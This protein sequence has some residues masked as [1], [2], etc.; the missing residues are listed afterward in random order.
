MST[1][2]RV[3]QNSHGI[4]GEIQSTGLQTYSYVSI[5]LSPTDVG[6]GFEMAMSR[7]W[8]KGLDFFEL[9][10][11][12]AQKAEKMLGAKV[13]PSKKMPVILDER[14]TGQT[15]GSIVGFGVNG[16]TVMTGISY[17]ADKIG[18]E[19][20]N[21][22]LNIWDDPHVSGGS[23]SRQLDAEGIPTTKVEIMN[24]GVLE[25]YVTDSY[26]ASVLGLE[27]TGNAGSGFRSNRP[28]PRV[29]QMQIGAGQD[30]K[31]QMYEDLKEGLIIESGLSGSGGSP[32]ISAQVNRGFY[33]KDG[34]IQYPLKNTMLG[35][36]V[37]ELLKGISGISK[38][39]KVEFGRQY[40]VMSLSEVS[41]AGAGDKKSGPS[42]S[43]TSI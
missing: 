40:P 26:T 12:G 37:F 41:I 25:S 6:V 43:M 10:K 35:T 29:H 3:V 4:Q 5:P 1:T 8:D 32:E 28:R 39:I 7:S 15:L 36:N 38:E 9:G 17:F 14:A 27:N 20:A 24:N 18:A 22:D 34:E 11:I 19:L 16:Y 33:V 2:E 23:S 31:E 30:S 13:A 42:I 21:A